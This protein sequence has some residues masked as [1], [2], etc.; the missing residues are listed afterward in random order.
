MW[1][2]LL[3]DSPGCHSQSCCGDLGVCV[4]FLD[5]TLEISPYCPELGSFTKKMSLLFVLSITPWVF[6][7]VLAPALARLRE[8]SPSWI[9]EGVCATSRTFL[10]VL[11]GFTVINAGQLAP[12]EGKAKVLEHGI[13]LLIICFVVALYLKLEEQ[14]DYCSFNCRPQ[15]LQLELY[16]LVP[17]RSTPT[18]CVPGDN[19]RP[20]IYSAFPLLPRSPSAGRCAFQVGVLW[21]GRNKREHVKMCSSCQL[22][23]LCI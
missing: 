19:T 17:V 12:M 7:R 21:K 23:S 1:M 6:C 16:F 14:K 2:S 18:M 10:Q 3:R 5:Q 9:G 8:S 20:Q 22:D 4:H 11:P 13:T 15:I